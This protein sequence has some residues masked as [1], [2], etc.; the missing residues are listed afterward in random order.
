MVIR[1][2]SVRVRFTDVPSC[3]IL[4]IENGSKT[5]RE[6]SLVGE[7]FVLGQRRDTQ[8]TWSGAVCL[9]CAE[10]GERSEQKT[11]DRQTD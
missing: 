11:Y 5:F 4:A 9:P 3:E 6:A 10:N 2:G 8:T 1:C 7:Q